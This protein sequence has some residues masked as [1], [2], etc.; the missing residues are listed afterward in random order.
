M[1]RRRSRTRSVLE[2]P[3][4]ST[5][6]APARASSPR[7]PPRAAMLISGAASNALVIG[8]E[9]MSRHV[10]PGDRNT[11]ALFGDGAAAIVASAGAS[12][13]SARSCS[14]QTAAH[15]ELIVADRASA[16]ARRW[17]ATRPSS[18]PS[19]GWAKRRGTPAR[20]PASRSPTSTSTSTTRPTRGSSRRSPSASSSSREGRR[21]HRELG[22]TSAASVP[23]AL[24]QAR[25]EGRLRRDARP[26]RRG[27]VGLHLGACVI[28][29]GRA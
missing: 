24:E 25:R 28:E 14:A 23:L 12:A 7:S 1:P 26:A 6:A 5:S 3:R 2:A 27:R 18:R 22:N 20:R 8:A 10:D 15:A 29:W 11:A 19:S 13:T 4:P 16:A 17:T 9:I 21:L